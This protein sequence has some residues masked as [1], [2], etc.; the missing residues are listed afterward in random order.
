MTSVAKDF[1][2]LSSTLRRSPPAYLTL[3]LAALLRHRLSKAVKITQH[4]THCPHFA[5][6]YRF[7]HISFLIGKLIPTGEVT[8]PLINP[9]WAN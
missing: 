5:L 4:P 3:P 7:L 9:F 1:L 8:M 2:T 6:G